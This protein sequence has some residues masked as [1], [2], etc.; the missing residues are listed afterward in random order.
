MLLRS[1]R[2]AFRSEVVA[3]RSCISTLLAD[4][5]AP[6]SGEH[7]GICWAQHGKG[8]LVCVAPCQ[9]RGG[10]CCRV[11]LRYACLAM[12]SSHTQNTS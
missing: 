8:A 2:D 4:P 7:L 1:R 12:G 11:G 3:L 9:R 5:C 10:F 6:G